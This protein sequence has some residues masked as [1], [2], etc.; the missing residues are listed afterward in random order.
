MGMLL[1]QSAVTVHDVKRIHVHIQIRYLIP[2]SFV[3][4][5]TFLLDDLMQPSPD[6]ITIHGS[7]C[8]NADAYRTR[9]GIQII[10]YGPLALAPLSITRQQH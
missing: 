5:R 2:D 4:L 6:F 1:S 10:G 8:G 7:H 9:A 3:H